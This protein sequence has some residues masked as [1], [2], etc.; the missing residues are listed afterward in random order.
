M[1]WR[2]AKYE[3]AYLSVGSS[4]QFVV[5]P[6]LMHNW[7][8]WPYTKEFFDRNR[9]AAQPPLAKPT[10]FTLYFPHVAAGGGWET[11]IALL[12]SS[13]AAPVSGILQ[14]FGADGGQPLES[15]A[16][17]LPPGGRKEIEASTFFTQ[18]QSV[19]YLAFNC[20]SAF[21]SGYTRFSQPGY[22]ATLPA[23]TGGKDGWFPKMEQDGW[24]GVAFVNTETETANVTLKAVDDNGTELA[25][26]TLS[27]PA[28]KKIVG[29]VYQIFKTD[30]SKAKYFKYRADRKLLGF[31][32]SASADGQMLD[33]I[34][35]LPEYFRYMW[36]QK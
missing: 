23:S 2:F 8:D 26:E 33:G 1:F 27:V 32:V 3:A 22:R 9:V 25:S 31:T 19:A 6:G 14:A 29:M 28:G 13:E 34:P 4:C 18:P 21:I 12:N 11:E 10:Q 15:V 5:F 36:R 16:V 20:D 17:T 24:T 7:A 35:A 30:I